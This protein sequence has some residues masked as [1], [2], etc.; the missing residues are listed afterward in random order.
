MF[1][2]FF[3]TRCICRYKNSKRFLNLNSSN[4][5]FLFGKKKFHTWISLFFPFNFPSPFISLCFYTPPS[6][7]PAIIFLYLLKYYST[8]FFFPP[9]PLFF[10]TVCLPVINLPFSF[11]VI[12]DME[13]FLFIFQNCFSSLSFLQHFLFPSPAFVFP[14]LQLKVLRFNIHAKFVFCLFFSAIFFFFSF[15]SSTTTSSSSFLDFFPTSF[16]FL[17]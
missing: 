7:L 12:T 4:F 3:C 16:T 15:S 8:F 14:T 9:P 17:V 2:F 6:P 10:R 1:F 5:F 11:E 13:I